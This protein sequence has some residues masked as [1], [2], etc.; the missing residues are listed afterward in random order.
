MTMFTQKQIAVFWGHVKRSGGCWEWQASC[1]TAGYG[2]IR[3]NRKLMLAH[4]VSYIL[5]N[6]EIPNGKFVCHTCDNRKCVNPAHLW[7]GTNAENVV[8]RDNKKRGAVGEKS[9]RAKLTDAQVVEIRAKH[10]PGVM[11]YRK[12]SKMFNISRF[13]IGA[14]I[15]GTSRK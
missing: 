1:D 11:G 2:T 3:I 14:I 12:L 9:G 7:I 6:G 13:Q 8:D 4:R 10:I 15:R 5:H